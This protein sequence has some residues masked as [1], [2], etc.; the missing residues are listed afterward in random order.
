MGDGTTAVAKADEIVATSPRPASSNDFR[1]T[2][3]CLSY[4]PTMGVPDS[5]P[6]LD[7]FRG[8]G[9]ERGLLRCGG[10]RA[11]SGGGSLLWTPTPPRSPEDMRFR[12]TVKVVEWLLTRQDVDHNGFGGLPRGHQGD[13]DQH[14]CGPSGMNSVGHS[15][16][17]GSGRSDS[18][19]VKDSNL[20]TAD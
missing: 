15:Q 10:S 19:A 14:C 13:S 2:V 16:C 20:G 5:P 9:A 18:W 7:Q 4:M 12:T 3:I 11:S 8:V 17:S 1:A 6:R